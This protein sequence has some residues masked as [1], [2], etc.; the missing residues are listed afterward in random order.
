MS[1]SV[2][3]LNIENHFHII[4]RQDG[5]TGD[6]IMAEDSVV[7][8]AACQSAFL[9]ES[10]QYMNNLHCNQ[11]ET[12]GFVPIATPKLIAKK[13]EAKLIFETFSTFRNRIGLSFAFVFF[14]T[15]IVSWI[16]FLFY[17]NQFLPKFHPAITFTVY[18]TLYILGGLGSVFLLISISKNKLFRKII[19]IDKKTIRILENGMGIKKN[20][21]YSFY[22]MNEINYCKTKKENKISIYLKNGK[23]IT[24][25]FPKDNYQK[26]K[27]FLFALAWVAQFVQTRIYLENQQ[28]Y[29]IAKSIERNYVANF[30]VVDSLEFLH[31]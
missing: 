19:G 5:V 22:E 12:L 21:M 17:T 30:L 25:S 11:S 18:L 9:V 4:G 28:E 8:C 23:K 31:S 10:W 6:S 14:M 1:H 3:K 16:Y 26:T 24:H 20:K 13:K 29:G 7:F 2:H 27:D 15:S